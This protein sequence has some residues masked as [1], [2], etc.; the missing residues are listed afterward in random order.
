M[1][2]HV[3]QNFIKYYYSYNISILYLFFEYRFNL[4]DENFY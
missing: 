4:I 1:Q 3:W 2:T